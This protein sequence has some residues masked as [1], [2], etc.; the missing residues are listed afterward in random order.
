VGMKKALLAALLI[1]LLFMVLAAR[2][3]IGDYSDPEGP[4]YE[5]SYADTAPPFDGRLRVVS[6]NLHY[7]QELKQIIETLETSDELRDADILLLQ[8]LNSEGAE[9]LAQEL[10]YDYVYYP[11]AMDRERQKEYGNAILSKWPLRDE[12]KLVLP[13]SLPGW[14]EDRNAAR[15]TTTVDGRDILL[16]SAHLDTVWMDPQGEFLGKEISQHPEMAILG[17][18]FNSWRSAS[19]ASLQ[20]ALKGAGMQRLAE[21]TGYTFSLLGL[22]L[23]LDHIF[24]AEGLDYRAGVLR[25]T[26]ASDHLPVWADIIIGDGE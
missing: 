20:R 4:V 23:T 7:G 2:R 12:R 25:Q 17:G 8:E 26:E 10:H 24:T 22:P 9:A 16:Y 21:G 18:D 13:N 15:A 11:A 1:I 19:I 3:P 5:G 6:W 14:L